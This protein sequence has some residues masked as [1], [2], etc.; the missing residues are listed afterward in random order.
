LVLRVGRKLV[1]ARG[2]EVMRR[3]WCGA[4]FVP[5]L[6]KTTLFSSKLQRPLSCGQ[7]KIAHV[8]NSVMSV[9]V[10]LDMRKFQTQLSTEFEA[11]AWASPTGQRHGAFLNL[12]GKSRV[13][14]NKNTG[15]GRTTVKQVSRLICCF[16]SWS[17]PEGLSS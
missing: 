2:A 8:A 3:K 10:P 15:L 4:N 1:S 11:H 17:H 13:A 12:G 9:F 7:F 14:E 6:L 5:H 16:V